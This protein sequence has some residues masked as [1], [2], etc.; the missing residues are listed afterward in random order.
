MKR[1]FTVFVVILLALG[2]IVMFLPALFSGTH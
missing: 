1:A 2:M